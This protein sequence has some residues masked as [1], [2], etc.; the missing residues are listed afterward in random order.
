[1]SGSRRHQDRLGGLYAITD[2]NLIPAQRFTEAIEQ[3]LQ[4]GAR[5]IQYRDKS[6]DHVKRRQQ[7][8]ELC[9]LCR[10]YQAVAIIN[11]DL[12]LASTVDADGVHL[13]KHDMHMTEARKKLGNN[14]IIGVS[15]YND[16]S[17]AEKAADHGADYIAF[18]A[19]F[20]SPTKPQAVKASPDLIVKAK[21]QLDIAVCT[22]GGI[23]TGNA[24]QLVDYG[25]DMIAVISALYASKQIRETAEQFSACFK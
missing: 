9:R 16:F 6:T 14:A 10:Q 21:Q 20:T 12:E 2:E 13:G 1:M 11:D 18:G 23:D 17:L 15:C 7:A 25:A 24:K 5:I 22:I 4:G 19:M 3:A 8:G